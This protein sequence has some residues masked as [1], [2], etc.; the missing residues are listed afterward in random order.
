VEIKRKKVELGRGAGKIRRV[1]PGEQLPD[2]DSLFD[3]RLVEDPLGNVEYVG[4]VE[5]DSAEE[6]SAALQAIKREKA[7]RRDHYRLLTDTEFW[8]AV[9][10]QSREQKE[11]FL[12]K[13]GWTRAGLADK[14]IDGL[15]LARLLQVDVEP[16]PLPIPERQ[17]APKGLRENNLIRR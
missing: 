7:E 17:R 2:F 16:I 3:A 4:D 1:R 13:A 6:I 11:E 9:C 14:Y 12:E 15:A 8:F 10:F 5:E